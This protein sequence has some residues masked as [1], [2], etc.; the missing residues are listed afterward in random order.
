MGPRFSEMIIIF[1]VPFN[2]LF[3]DTNQKENDTFSENYCRII[4]EFYRSVCALHTRYLAFY[5]PPPDI[6]T[7]YKNNVRQCQGLVTLLDSWGL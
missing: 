4:L 5:E 6:Q 2:S 3:A 1:D 7:H